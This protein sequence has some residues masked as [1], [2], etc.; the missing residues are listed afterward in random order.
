M[1]PYREEMQAI[2]LISHEL[3][4][5]IDD[6]A[7]PLD[8]IESLVVEREKRIR[9]FFSSPLVAERQA[10]IAAWIQNLMAIDRE[11]M[12]ILI[13]R[14]QRLQKQHA[15]MRH[16]AHGIAEYQQTDALDG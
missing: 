13:E 11:A 5:A 7:V 10:E 16:Q 8:R 4:Q 14:Q 3:R 2:M 15:A 6:E 12:E 9:R 1:D